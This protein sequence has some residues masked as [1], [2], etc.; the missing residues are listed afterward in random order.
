[1]DLKNPFT[2]FLILITAN[3]ISYGLTIAISKLWNK[4]YKYQ[5][6][7]LKKE[8]IGSILTLLINIL[9]AIPGYILWINDVIIFSESSIWLSFVGLFLLMDFL[10]YILHYLSHSIGLLNKI[11]SKHHEHS[12]KFNCI[13]LYHMS[14]WESIFFG[15]L[16]TMVTILFQFNIYGFILFLFFNWLYGLITH[17]NGSTYTPYLFIFTT[18]TFHKA[19]HKLDNRN[20]GFYTFLWDKLF[21]TEEKDKNTFANKE[22]K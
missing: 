1:M 8:I 21:K 5:E 11:H 18:N 14:P 12:D 15:L 19:H 17:L 7:L 9:I 22:L 13:S 6:V 16:L 20:F 10:M 2:F 3:I 4:I